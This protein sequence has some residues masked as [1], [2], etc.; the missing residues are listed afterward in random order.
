MPIDYPT[1]ILV[2][3]RAFHYLL[4]KVFLNKTVDRTLLFV[5]RRKWILVFGLS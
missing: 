4:L 2:L 3:N 5:N 1:S